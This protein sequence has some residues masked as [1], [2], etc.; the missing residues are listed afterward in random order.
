MKDATGLAN[1][2]R[3]RFRRA[4]P[5]LLV[6]ALTLWIIAIITLIAIDPVPGSGNP[7]D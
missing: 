4:I 1:R 3:S 5:A 7:M 2:E 6:L